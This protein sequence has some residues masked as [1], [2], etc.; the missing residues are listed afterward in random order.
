M[1]RLE[2]SDSLPSR[3]T[4][5]SIA[6]LPTLSVVIASLITTWPIMADAPLLPPF[7][8]LV[9]IAWRLMRSDVWPV[10][11]GIPLG[12]WDDLFSGQPVGSAVALW[13]IVMLAMDLV[14]ARLVWRDYRIDWLIG[15]LA[16]GFVLVAGAMLARAGDVGGIGALIAPQIG[17]ALFALPA[18]MLLVARLDNW[19]LGR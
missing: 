14:D 5:S 11:I 9:L 15:G 16:V 7:G 10:W 8:F 4:G 17:I 18:T 3:A 12:F 13:T 2:L 1:N 19:R 6:I